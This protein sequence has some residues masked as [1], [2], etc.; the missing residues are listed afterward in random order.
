GIDGLSGAAKLQRDGGTPLS[1]DAE[2]SP[3]DENLAYRNVGSR[4]SGHKAGPAAAVLD[5]D[6]PPITP[7][8]SG[9]GHPAR[10]RCDDL[11]PGAR[12]QSDTAAS[13]GGGRRS[14]SGQR[15]SGDGK[16]I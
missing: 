6:D 1:R 14:E 16:N 8:G 12:R 10:R 7:I 4:K 2:W 15:P 9:E 11:R 5:H 3:S 13:P